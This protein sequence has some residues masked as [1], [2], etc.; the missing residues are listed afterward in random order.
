[1][2]PPRP[3]P[4]AAPPKPSRPSKDDLA[5]LDA[6]LNSRSVE[7]PLT[8]LEKPAPAWEP[9]FT[10][11]AGPRGARRSPSGL[12][13]PLL[14]AGLV[15]LLGGAF[16]A[17][18]FIGATT[19]GQAAVRP[20]AARARAT[21]APPAQPTPDPTAIDASTTAPS[22]APLPPDVTRPAAG[23]STPPAPITPPGAPAAR[24]TPV[25]APPAGGGL[26]DARALLRQGRLSDAAQGFV[27]H[28]RKAGPG[29][30]SIQMLVAC[31]DE[32]V[33][34][35]LASVPEPDL[36]IL[37][38][39][40]KGRPCYRVCWGLY[41]DEARALSATRSLPDYFRTSGS[42]PRVVPTSGLLP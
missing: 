14:A 28:L 2:P 16:I 5:A 13:L 20:P 38:V 35:A 26:A 12:R 22:P 36:Y 15:V 11:P 23:A 17:W 10:Q 37:P 6:L 8:P 27:Q 4:G 19:P 3:E 24:A 34:K 33:E 32:T 21:P 1:V 42:S 41:D 30:F 18:R 39:N 7:G 31:S 29:T 25:P 40:Y 9:R